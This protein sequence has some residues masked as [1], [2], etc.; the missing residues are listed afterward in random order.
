MRGLSGVAFALGA[1]SWRERELCP[2]VQ[3]QEGNGLQGNVLLQGGA[4][5]LPFQFRLAHACMDTGQGWQL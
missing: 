4:H 2:C 1:A 3:K 5:A